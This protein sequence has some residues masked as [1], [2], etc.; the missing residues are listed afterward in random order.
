MFLDP[1]LTDHTNP[2]ALVHHCDLVFLLFGGSWCPFEKGG[3]LF[4]GEVH[5]QLSASN[6]REFHGPG[7][8]RV[9]PCFSHLPIKW[10]Q[11]ACGDG[12]ECTRMPEQGH[13]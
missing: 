3:G 7:N 2:Q 4:L 13:L 6:V 12:S 11:V 5:T 10:G 9:C 8:S 1:P